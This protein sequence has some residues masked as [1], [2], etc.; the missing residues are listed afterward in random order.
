VVGAWA[1]NLESRTGL[2]ILGL[3]GLGGRNLAGL[4]SVVKTKRRQES[5]RRALYAMAVGEKN[6]VGK[7]NAASFG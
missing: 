6:L 5:R 1:G 7:N 4:K 3:Q 2:P